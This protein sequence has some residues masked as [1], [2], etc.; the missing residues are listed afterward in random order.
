MVTTTDCT[1]LLKRTDPMRDE[2]IQQIVLETVTNLNLA[3]QPQDQ[4]KVSPDAPIFGT[5][6]PLDSMG[7]VALI[8]D[9]E[10]AFSHG[11]LFHNSQ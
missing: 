2:R 7:L 3:R 10:E 6:S 4:L 1:L 8:M 11:R 9:I 5:S